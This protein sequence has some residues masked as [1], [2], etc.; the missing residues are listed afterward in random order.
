MEIT[1]APGIEV[2]QPEESTKPTFKITDDGKAQWAIRKIRE[3]EQA[4]AMWTRHY[5]DQLRKLQDSLN[6]DIAYFTRL[7]EDYFDTCPQ[8]V[9]KTQ[10]KYKL[11]DAELIRKAVQ[12]TYICDDDVLVAFLKAS[13]RDTFIKVIEKP[14][15]AEYKKAITLVNGQAVDAETGE[16]VQGVMVQQ[17]PP[18]FQVKLKEDF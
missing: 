8:H 6:G 12:P 14:D 10:A 15:W 1:C 3:A 5:Q 13:K 18:V 16:I 17:N 7:L 4:K 2:L 11:P 9:T